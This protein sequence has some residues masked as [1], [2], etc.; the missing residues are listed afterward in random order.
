M[1]AIDRLHAEAISRGRDCPASDD[2]LYS[3]QCVHSE[4]GTCS[5][6]AHATNGKNG[7]WYVASN[8][9]RI[10]T[11]STGGTI[12]SSLVAWSV[13]ELEDDSRVSRRDIYDVLLISDVP[14]SDHLSL[15][16]QTYA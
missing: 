1:I 6:I 2:A 13:R 9:S 7:N 14:V 11:C 4:I 10:Y 3:L 5:A 15:L 16:V 12:S 8:R